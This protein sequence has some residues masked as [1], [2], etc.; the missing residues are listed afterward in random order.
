M[1]V[2]LLY[3]SHEWSNKTLHALLEGKGIEIEMIDVERDGIVDLSGYKLIINRVFPSACL[4]GNN[5]AFSN[6]VEM[7]RKIRGMAIKQ[8]NSEEAFIYDFDKNATMKNLGG[9]GIPTPKCLNYF[10]E[11]SIEYPCIVKPVTGGRSLDTEI[12]DCE[13]RLKAFFSTREPSK[14]VIQEYHEP[15]KG[16]TTRIEIVGSDFISIFK[17][18]LGDGNIGSYNRGSMYIPYPDCPDEIVNAC[19][20]SLKI[21][22]MEMA[23]FDVIE[24]NDNFYV[25]DVNPTSNFAEENIETFGYNLMAMMANHIVGV[26]KSL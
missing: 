21:L 10:S 5:Q 20:E 9:I 8:V 16:F 6:T 1:T 14:F 17:R 19:R 11:S 4:R 22:E 18:S 26:Y 23:S 15:V 24:T 2:A 3:E 25:I 12:I 13:K 7:L